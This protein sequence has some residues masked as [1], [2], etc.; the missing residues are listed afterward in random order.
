MAAL[1]I[2]IPPQYN[3][4]VLSSF[5]KQSNQEEVSIILEPTLLRYVTDFALQCFNE[6]GA[7][8]FGRVD[9]KL[10]SNGHCAFIEINLTPGLNQNSSYFPQAYKLNKMLTFS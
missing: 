1:E 4:T 2:L 9:I 3:T 5:I 8:D 10:D 7:R 6:L